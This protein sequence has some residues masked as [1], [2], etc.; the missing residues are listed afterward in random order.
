MSD[1]I[2]GAFTLAAVAAALFFVKYWRKSR[3]RMF[4]VF[5]LAFV[6][7]AIERTGLTFVS[8]EQD[9]RHLIFLARLLAFGLIIA[10]ILDKNRSRESRH[11]RERGASSTLERAHVG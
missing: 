2:S 9:G 1:F 3:D 6:L 7:L 10:G 11:R 4:A 5:A 8:I